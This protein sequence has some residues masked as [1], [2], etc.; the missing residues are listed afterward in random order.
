MAIDDFNGLILEQERPAV[1]IQSQACPTAYNLPRAI[2]SSNKLEF[3]NPKDVLEEAFL[4]PKT[5][6]DKEIRSTLQ[7]G[8]IVSNLQALN[9]I[10]QKLESDAVLFKGAVIYNLFELCTTVDQANEIAQVYK[11]YVKTLWPKENVKPLVVHLQSASKD[12]EFDNLHSFY[13][14]ETSSYYSMIDYKFTK[15]TLDN[16]RGEK[17]TNDTVSSTNEE[18]ESEEKEKEEESPVESD[19]EDEAIQENQNEEEQQNGETQEGETEKPVQI[20]TK[21][22]IKPKLIPKQIFSR[23]IKRPEDQ[24]EAFNKES[25]KNALI[26][27]IIHDLYIHHTEMSRLVVD[28]TQLFEDMVSCVEYFLKRLHLKTIKDTPIRITAFD[29]NGTNIYV[30]LNPDDVI[31]KH[32]SIEGESELKRKLSLFQRFCPVTFNESQKL[33][34]GALEHCVVYKLQVF[35]F[36]SA[37]KADRFYAYPFRYLRRIP[38][39]SNLKVL[40]LG[41]PLSGTSALAKNLAHSLGLVLLSPQDIK[42]SSVLNTG[43]AVSLDQFIKLSKERIKSENDKNGWVID[44]LANSIPDIQ[45][46]IAS[47]LK[48]DHIIALKY[49]N[50][51]DL[52]DKCKQMFYKQSDQSVH[53]K[54]ITSINPSYDSYSVSDPLGDDEFLVD[55]INL[56]KPVNAAYEACLGDLQAFCD[57][58]SISTKVFNANTPLYKLYHDIESVVSPIAYKATN[59]ILPEESVVENPHLELSA[60]ADYCP[61]TLHSRN[62]L[63]KGDPLYAVTYRGQTYTFVNQEKM[64]QFMEHPEYYTNYG[65]KIHIPKPRI[66]CVGPAM[67]GKVRIEL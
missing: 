26:S 34:S 54:K 56:L 13:D 24:R 15:F 10:K 29:E 52:A 67:S 25:E 65:R 38:S 18:G 22:E 28:G 48:P 35:Y 42:D 9:L 23:L 3:I 60:V 40:L 30:G 5:D 6:L 2:A 36:E 63:R 64:Q 19:D 59:I 45:S 41:P 39:V 21:V 14:P 53:I 4:N 8:K 57:S 12:L 62:V 47:D 20:E 50:P 7:S 32:L 27:N 44:C 1:L 43:G 61:V 55:E 16:K 11:S 37:Q 17:D 31:A 51:T 46:I 49:E 66:M 33:Q 58:N